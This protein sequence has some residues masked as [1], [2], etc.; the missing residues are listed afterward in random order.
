MYLDTVSSIGQIHFAH[1]WDFL[2]LNSNKGGILYRHGL[3]EMIVKSDN[4]GLERSVDE[5]WLTLDTT[6]FIL[7]VPGLVFFGAF[8]YSFWSFSVSLLTGSQVCHHWMR[9]AFCLLQ[10]E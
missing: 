4:C 9:P 1:H 3:H 8:V 10:L 2:N 7:L 6:L 5:V